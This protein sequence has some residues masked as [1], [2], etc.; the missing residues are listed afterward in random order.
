MRPD[1]EPRS[2]DVVDAGCEAPPGL[3]GLTKGC[4]CTCF[5]CGNPVC[6]NCSRIRPYLRFGRRRICLNCVEELERDQRRRAPHLTTDALA[7]IRQAA[8]ST[9]RRDLAALYGLSVRE[10]ARI[11]HGHPPRSPVT[12]RTRRDRAQAT[13][14]KTGQSGRR[15]ESR[16]VEFSGAGPAAP[17]TSS[18]TSLTI[19]GSCLA[20]EIGATVYYVLPRSPRHGRPRPLYLESEV[21]NITQRSVVIRPKHGQ[22]HHRN[23]KA[24][25]LVGRPP[26]GAWVL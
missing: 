10:V 21:L 17:I 14:A 22:R 11:Q 16:T 12:Y 9:S 20:I 6:K 23:V 5:K 25:S 18:G 26:E 7:I 13:K 24:T 4:R 19:W 2:C 3:A 1:Q 15:P 8:R